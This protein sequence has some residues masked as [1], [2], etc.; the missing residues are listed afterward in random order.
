MS[1]RSGRPVARGTG[2]H[3][4][5]PATRRRAADCLSGGRTGGGPD[6]S[7]GECARPDGLVRPRDRCR[8]PRPVRTHRRWRCARGAQRRGQ[9]HDAAR[10]RRCASPHIGYCRDRRS[11]SGPRPPAAKQRTGYC[12]DVGG[13][14]PRATPWEH[15]ALAARLRRLPAGWETRARSL[16]DRFD[17]TSS[18]DRITAGFSHGMSRRMSVVLAAFHDPDVLLL[19]EP[20][21]GST[22]LALRRPSTWSP[23]CAFVAAPWSWLDTC[24]HTRSRPARRL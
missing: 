19:D 4:R 16:L 11:G 23:T 22:R 17:L 3:E 20:F 24:S 8:R 21:D 13:L 5:H 7:R 14:I 6:A 1:R 9:V 2:C 18:S 15:L 12:P 10:A